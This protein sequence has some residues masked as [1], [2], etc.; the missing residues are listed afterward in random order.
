MNN[1]YL[2]ERLENFKKELDVISEAL[3][4]LASETVKEQ[5]CQIQ[6]GNDVKF[7]KDI[8]KNLFKVWRAINKASEYLEK[9]SQMLQQD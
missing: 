1:K 9:T 5:L 6:D 4:E 2:D 3:Y 8:E 7:L